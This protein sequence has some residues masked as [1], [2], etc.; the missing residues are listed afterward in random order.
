MTAL[1]TRPEP[2]VVGTPSASS[3][4]SGKPLQEGREPSIVKGG[5]AVSPFVE[6]SP[7][8]AAVRD[9]RSDLSTKLTTAVLA[10]IMIKKGSNEPVYGPLEV[11]SGFDKRFKAAF[12]LAVKL[13]FVSYE[14]APSVRVQVEEQ[15]NAQGL[16]VLGW[17]DR[18]EKV[19]VTDRAE[20]AEFLKSPEWQHEQKVGKAKWI[21]MA[22]VAAAI[23]VLGWIAGLDHLRDAKTHWNYLERGYSHITY[24]GSP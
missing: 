14:D 10:Q 7:I 12:G 22:G 6:A 21:A 20:F 2:R 19:F 18:T 16:Q 23:P 5:E 13:P 3:I 9:R 4:D 15:L 24:D 17:D 1:R 8:A 11:G